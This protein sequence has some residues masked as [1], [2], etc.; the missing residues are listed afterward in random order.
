MKKTL[1]AISTA[2]LCVIVCVLTVMIYTWLQ[3][4]LMYFIIAA[5]ATIIIGIIFRK[6]VWS[7]IKKVLSR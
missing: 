7:G 4:M 1:K 3:K 6:Q 2:I 5:V